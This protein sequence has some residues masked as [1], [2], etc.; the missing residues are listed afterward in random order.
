[1]GGQFNHASLACVLHLYLDVSPIYQWRLIDYQTELFIAMLL[2]NAAKEDKQKSGSKI[3]SKISNY[4][5]Y[6]NLKMP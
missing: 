5:M 1:M 6:N 3:S 4:G 2:E